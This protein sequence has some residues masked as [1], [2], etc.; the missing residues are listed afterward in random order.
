MSVGPVLIHFSFVHLCS[1]KLLHIRWT[2]GTRS[3]DLGL[4]G[5]VMSV[6]RTH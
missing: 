6:E 1:L 2:L 5:Q 4:G 3:C